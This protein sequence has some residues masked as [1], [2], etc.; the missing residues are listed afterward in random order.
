MNFMTLHDTDMKDK[1]LKDK[2]SDS[3]N[4]FNYFRI[5]FRSYDKARKDETLESWDKKKKKDKT[6]KSHASKPILLIK[7]D[8]FHH[9]RYL[10]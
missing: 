1:S 9:H 7:T 2:T 6:K 3:Y 4:Q 5:G 10:W 8:H